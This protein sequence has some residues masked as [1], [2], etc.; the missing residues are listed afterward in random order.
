MVDYVDR[1]FYVEPSL[2]VW[3]EVELIIVDDD[4]DVFLDSLFMIILV[5][6]S[7]S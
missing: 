1:F 6:N 3:D 4:S 7:L 5:C 2:N